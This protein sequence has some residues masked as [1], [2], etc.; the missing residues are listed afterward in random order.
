MCP[1][2]ETSP[3]LSTHIRLWWKCQVELLVFV[4][5][6]CQ[7]V[8]WGRVADGGELR[9]GGWWGFGRTQAAS[10]CSEFL[11]CCQ[12]SLLSN[13]LFLWK[14]AQSHTLLAHWR[15]ATDKSCGGIACFFLEEWLRQKRVYWKMTYNLLAWR[16]ACSGDTDAVC[17]FVRVRGLIYVAF[18]LLPKIWAGWVV[19]VAK[20]TYVSLTCYCCKDGG[21]LSWPDFFY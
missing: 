20:Q 4:W 11:R 1:G 15:A 10:A 17:G 5:G 6:S 14:H 7:R 13:Y 18:H 9:W 2:R 16:T 12:H 19:V 8:V 3:A 21:L